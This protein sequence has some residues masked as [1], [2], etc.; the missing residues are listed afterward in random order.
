[1]KKLNYTQK[2]LIIVTLIALVLCILVSYCWQKND[3]INKECEN[4]Q[5]DYAA[6][7]EELHTI[8][9]EL[10]KTKENLQIEIER[11]IKLNEDLI[12]INKKLEEA[13]I[14][15]ADVKSNEYQLVY[16]G[17]FKITHYCVEL[18]EHICGTGSGLTAT[19]TDVTV[20][21]TIAVDPKVIPYGTQV[22]I[23][24]YG[25][26]IAEDCGG[27]VKGNHIDVAVDTHAQA[28]DMGITSG[29]VWILVPV[30]T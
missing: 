29:G 5:D 15:I 9:N 2:S 24:G 3:Q 26:R 4:I 10:L 8:Q 27:A 19:G 13:N 11:S 22:Y 20:G 21:R 6:M 18:Y 16:I 28:M 12:D 7:T 17:D 1:M 30:T 23:E 25:W 14:T